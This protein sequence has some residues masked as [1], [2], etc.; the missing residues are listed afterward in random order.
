MMA[1]FLYE[2]VIIPFLHSVHPFS[3]WILSK[4]Q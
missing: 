4:V 1:G 2:T 3:A